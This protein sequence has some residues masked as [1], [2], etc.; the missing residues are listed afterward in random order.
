VK[1]WVHL[2]FTGL[3]LAGG[4]SHVTGNDVTTSRHR[5]WRNL[6][7][8]QP[9]LAVGGLYVKFG[10]CSSSYRAVTRRRWQ[11]CD[12]KWCHV[13]SRDR[14][15]PGSDVIW[16]NLTE[17]GCRRPVSQVLCMFE[18]LPGCNSQ[19]VAFTWQEMMSLNWK[20]PESDVTWPELTWK[21][22]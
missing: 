16:P 20:W 17:S 9:E 6:T 13:T 2:S 19:E 21:C 3:Q 1:F 10:V 22:L 4:G 7:R 12:R 15:W 14:K 8:N 5:K 11:S 18:F